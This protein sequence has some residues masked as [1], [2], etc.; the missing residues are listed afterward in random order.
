MQRAKL[1]YFVDGVIALAFLGSAVSGIVF[2]VPLEWATLSTETAPTFLGL[3]F[4]VWNSL[5][6]CSSL[7]MMG[8]VGL[9]LVLHATWLLN[10][11]RQIFALPKKQKRVPDAMTQ[12]RTA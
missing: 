12:L 4:R 5:H 10:M 6:I 9:H 3:S 1:N 7:A 2:L 8:G 11:T